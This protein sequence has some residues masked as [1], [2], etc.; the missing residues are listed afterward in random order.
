[1][2]FVKVNPTSSARRNFYKIDNKNL[3]RKTALLK[4]KTHRKSQVEKIEGI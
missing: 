3:T 1:M 2:V 4:I